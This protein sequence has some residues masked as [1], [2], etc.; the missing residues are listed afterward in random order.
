MGNNTMYSIQQFK[1]T[2]TR[3]LRKYS[4][5]TNLTNK[6]FNWLPD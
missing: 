1:E 2:M 5:T 6:M 3:K 4:Y